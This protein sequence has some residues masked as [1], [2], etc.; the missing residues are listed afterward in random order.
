MDNYTLKTNVDMSQL[1]YIKI[2]GKIKE[3]YL[4]NNKKGVKEVYALL[5]KRNYDYYLIGGCSKILFPDIFMRECLIKNNVTFLK[6]HKN[7]IEVGTGLSLKKLAL[8]MIKKGYQ[9]F[10]GLISIPGTIGGAIVNN[11][12][13]FNNEISDTIISATIF[14]DGEFKILSKED[15][16]FSYRSSIFKKEEVFIYSAYFM[17]KKSTSDYLIKIAQEN[18]KKRINNQP[19]NKLTLGSTFKN[20]SNFFVAKVLADLNVLGLKD[21]N[22]MVSKKHA[23]FIENV[24]FATQKNFLNIVVILRNLVYNKLCIFPELEVIVLRWWRNVSEL[25]D[26]NILVDVSKFNNKITKTR[27]K[28]FLRMLISSISSFIILGCV[29]AYV[30]SPLSKVK[31]REL[32]GN[33]YLN[34]EDVL[35]FAKVS[36]NDS[37]LAINKE[38]MIKNLLD[39]SYV[40]SPSISWNLTYLDVYVDE[41]APMAK[42]ENNE[43]LLSNGL[44][45]S[46]YQTNH[47]DYVLKDNVDV[48]NL[49]IYRGNGKEYSKQLLSS[50]KY[51]DKELFASVSYVD[52]GNIKSDTSEGTYYGVYFKLENEEYLRIRFESSIVKL[53]LA[54]DEVIKSALKDYLAFDEVEVDGIMTREALCSCS[55]SSCR[56][57]KIEERD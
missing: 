24:G 11:A 3:L 40:S 31:I 47:N 49:P 22:V 23:N 43:I 41:I 51:L 52:V 20:S 30:F 5:K 12:G 4:I 55:D 50:L 32:S 8:Y 38:N 53:G 48:S 44:T 9:G 26:E 25:E 27:Q 39:S 21:E 6:E 18:I 54:K 16:N 57:S 36:K 29:G 1:S 42:N 7:Y 19:F 13:A 45:Y 46:Y 56:I 37:L 14:K 34:D 33:Y 2:G 17:I 28:V 15:M 10:E 35:R